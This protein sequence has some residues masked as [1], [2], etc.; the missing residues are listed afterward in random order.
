VA[1]SIIREGFRYAD[2]FY[3]TALPVTSDRLDL[4]VK[5]NTRKSFGNYLIILCLSDKI[6]DYYSSEL[7][8]HGLKGLAVENILTE[9]PSSRNENA[10]TVYLLPNYYVK[11]YINH[12]TGE[13]VSNPDFKPSYDSPAFS[14]NIELLKSAD[15]NIVE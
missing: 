7:D 5:H 9:N 1:K 14:R 13:I 11:G 6:V 4:L 8:R 3:K 2:S 12:Q 10:D 15:K